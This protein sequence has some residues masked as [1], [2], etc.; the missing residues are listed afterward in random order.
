MGILIEPVPYCIEKLKLL[1]CDRDRF[2]IDQVAVGNT[3]GTAKFYYVS[4]D[5]TLSLPE[6]PSWYDQLGSFDRQHIVKHLEGKLEPFILGM[7]VRVDTLEN[8]LQQHCVTEVHFLHIDTEGH[9]L[10]VI[11]SVNLSIL[12]PLAIW[13]EHKHLS[14]KDKC[15]MRSFL[16]KNGYVVSDSV[17]DFF[18]VHQDAN[19]RMHRNSTRCSIN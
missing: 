14:P 18:A 10:K 7:D 3:I 5:A 19:N 17:G 15:E 6:L 1:Y 4:E 11:K 16:E 2:T 9:D 8:I 12:A 13:V